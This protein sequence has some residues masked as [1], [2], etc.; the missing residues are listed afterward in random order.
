M[1][2]FRASIRRSRAARPSALEDPDGVAER[3]TEAHVGA[4]EVV[5]RL[6]REVVDTA[7]LERLVEPAHIVRDEDEAA[8]GAL[9][10][11]LAELLGGGLVVEGR[12]G[13]LEQDLGVRSPG[14]RTVSQR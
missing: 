2:S 10:D 3:V 5:D 1:G 11:Q 6:L 9:G 4:V 8:Q 12:A 7:L 13:L 14:T